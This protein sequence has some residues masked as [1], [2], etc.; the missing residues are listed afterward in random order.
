MA[1]NENEA[2]ALV[3]NC[4]PIEFEPRH[5]THVTPCQAAVLAFQTPKQVS[6]FA[7]NS[8][9]VSTQIIL[10]VNVVI[11]SISKVLTNLQADSR[12]KLA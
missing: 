10:A 4:K 3:T 8:W 2:T 9:Q 11:P 12:V 7:T 6:N 5:H 1:R